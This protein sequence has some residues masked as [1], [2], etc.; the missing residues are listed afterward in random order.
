MAKYVIDYRLLKE[1]DIILINENERLA[2]MMR[3]KFDH[4][5]YFAGGIT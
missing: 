2:K 5:M 1:G 3:S 4:V